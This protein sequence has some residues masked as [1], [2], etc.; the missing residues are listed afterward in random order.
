MKTS[1]FKDRSLSTRFSSLYLDYDEYM[2]E[3]RDAFLRTD[4]KEKSLYVFII[5]R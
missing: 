2:F 5:I 1:F 4:K 3:I